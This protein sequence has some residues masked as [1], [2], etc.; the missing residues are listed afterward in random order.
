MPGSDTVCEGNTKANSAPPTTQNCQV[1]SNRP[2]ET[3]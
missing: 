3:A 2:A 1:A